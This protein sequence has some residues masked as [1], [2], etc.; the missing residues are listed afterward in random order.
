[1]IDEAFFLSWLLMC[2]NSI[3]VKWFWGNNRGPGIHPWTS[4][5]PETEEVSGA[6]WMERPTA[7]INGDII[8]FEDDGTSC[9]IGV[10]MDGLSLQFSDTATLHGLFISVGVSWH[11]ENATAIEK[12]MVV[13]SLGTRDTTVPL[14]E[15]TTT[16]TT[17]T[18]TTEDITLHAN[19]AGNTMDPFFKK[20]NEKAKNAVL[21]HSFLF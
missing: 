19:M 4:K 9:C 6:K 14:L 11:G 7:N 5:K 8:P 2:M 15:T 12:W 18:I 1:M 21:V 16:T 3:T 13:E 17:T 10:N 20:R